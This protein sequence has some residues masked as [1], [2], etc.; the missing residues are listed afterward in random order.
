MKKKYFIKKL[1]LLNKEGWT[2]EFCLLDHK[3]RTDYSFTCPHCNTSTNIDTI[4][5]V[6]FQLVDWEIDEKELLPYDGTGMFGK[7]IHC[8]GCHTSYYTGINYLEPNNGR[9]VFVLHNI[10]ELE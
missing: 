3:T 10:I 4:H 2:K 8:P 1:R 7:I 5:A 6:F 9:D